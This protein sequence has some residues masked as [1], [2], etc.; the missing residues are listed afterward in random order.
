MRHF[1]D[2]QSLALLESGKLP[3]N[4]NREYGAI[5]FEPV[6]RLEYPNYN[7]ERGLPLSEDAYKR[8]QRIMVL[9]LL[10]GLALLARLWRT[11]WTFI[12]EATT[13]DT[14]S[15]SKPSTT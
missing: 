14:S 7:M 12:S 13:E 9:L 10:G 11:P 4:W 1:F 3:G 6:Q 5:T 15:S 8:I 2:P